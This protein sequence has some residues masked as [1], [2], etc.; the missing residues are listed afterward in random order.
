MAHYLLH[1]LRSEIINVKKLGSTTAKWGAIGALL[2]VLVA[3]AGCNGTKE[4]IAP[5][6]GKAPSAA[7][8]A[9]QAQRESS[10]KM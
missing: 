6:A 4:T 5:D 9:D 8:K 7:E 2:G 1:L 3:S 10:G